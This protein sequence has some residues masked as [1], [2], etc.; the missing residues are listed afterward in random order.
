MNEIPRDDSQPLNFQH[1]M[2]M[3][4]ACVQYTRYMIEMHIRVGFI[5]F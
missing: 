2:G 4:I 1:L 5:L 3:L